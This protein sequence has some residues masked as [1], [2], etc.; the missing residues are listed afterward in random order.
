[1]GCT[2]FA[3]ILDLVVA[4]TRLALCSGNGETRPAIETLSNMV[5]FC[6]EICSFWLSEICEGI[7]AESPQPVFN[8]IPELTSDNAEWI[9]RDLEQK[10]ASEW[11]EEGQTWIFVQGVSRTVF[12]WDMSDAEAQN[13]IIQAFANLVG[14]ARAIKHLTRKASNALLKAMRVAESIDLV[15]EETK[16]SLT[17]S[18]IEQGGLH[19]VDLEFEKYACMVL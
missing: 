14:T 3:R 5:E 9:R 7:R 11:S 12:A 13:L 2:L 16:T 6:L 17:T 4:S 18:I 1:M 10:Q 8:S 15:T 19:C